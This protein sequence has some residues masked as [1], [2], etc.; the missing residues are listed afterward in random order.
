MTCFAHFKFKLHKDDSLFYCGH[1][2]STFPQ[3]S[4]TI[5]N[6]IQR[7]AHE[8]AFRDDGM[9]ISLIV[10]INHDTKRGAWCIPHHVIHQFKMAICVT[11]VRDNDEYKLDQLQ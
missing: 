2:V 9:T 5:E 4:V 7:L 3:P 11:I 1:V 10:D 8:A 6:R